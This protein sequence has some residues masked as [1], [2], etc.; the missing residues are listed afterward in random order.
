MAEA[1]TAYLVEAG[2]SQAAA[3]LTVQMAATFAIS[4]VATRVFAPDVPQTKD[5][6]SRQQVPPDTTTG[7]PVVYGDA[8]LGGKFVDA[9][10][11]ANQ[12]I[13]YYVMA[14]SC[15]SNNG[16]VTIDTTKMYYGDRLITFDPSN[17]T[18][19]ISLTDTA[20]NV[21][22]TIAGNNL[23]ISLYRSYANGTIVGLNT[24]V[25]PWENHPDVMHNGIPTNVNY[26]ATVETLDD[27]P[28]SASVNDGY[29]VQQAVVSGSPVNNVLYVWDGTLWN[30]T[31]YD[32]YRV[33]P[34][35]AWP[36][37]G[38]RMNG[39]V[40]AIIRMNYNQGANTTQLQP[41]T[42]KVSQYLN[43]TGCAKPGDVWYDY[44]TNSVY[45]GA[46][47]TTFVDSASAT[48]LNNYSDEL[49]TYTPSGG[50]ATQTTPR[51]RFNGV[52]DTG[53]TVLSN[54]DKIVTCCDSWMKYAV[55]EGSWA[56]VIN[57]AEI[58]SFSF[59]DSNIVGEI[60]VSAIDIS[61]AYNQIEAKF[62][63]STNRDQW[64]YVNQQVPSYLL[65]PNEPV[66]KY[67][68]TYDLI[69]DSVR[70]QYLANRILEQNREDLNVSFNSAYVGIQVNAGD[71]VSVTN[72]AYGWTNKLFRVMQ[73]KEVSLADGNLGASFQLIEYNSQ[74]YDNADITQY[75][76]APNGGLASSGFFSALI[77]PT[78]TDQ[79]QSAAVPS[80]SVDCVLP[81]TGR[82]TNITL[83]YSTVSTPSS[84]DWLVISIQNSVNSQPFTNG[85]TIKF[86][87]I[88]LPTNV[89]YFAFRVG[90]E[91]SQS[92]LSPTSTSFNWLP[93]P[94]S[95]SVAG[96]FVATWSPA[97]IQV[98]YNGTTA[99]FT[100]IVPQL[101]G[102]TSGGS[103]DF[104]LASSDTDPLFVDNSWRIGA[105]PLTGFSDIVKTNITI[106]NPTDGGNY[107]LFPTPTAM[108]AN[109]ATLEVPVRY[110]DDLGNIVQGATA[111]L[112]FA[113]AVQGD[114]GA[115]GS[116][117]ATAVLYQWSTSTPSNPNGTSTFTWATSS[118]GSYTGGNGWTTS[119]GANPGIPLIK[120]FTATKGISAPGNDVTTA[121]SW[122]SGFSVQEFTQ[123]GDNGT[124]GANGI[125]SANPT[126]YQWA[127]TIPS[128]PSGTSTYTWSSNTFTPT[129]AGW[130]LTGGT[131]PSEGYTL[132]AARVNLVESAT[133]TTSTINWT[134]S[135]IGAV[136]YAGTTGSTGT[137]GASARICY[138][139][140]TLSSLSSSPST[141]TTSGS[142]SYPPNDSWGSGTVWQATPPSIVAG[143][144]V[145]QSDGIYSPT[146]GNTI[147][148]VP[149]LSALKVGSLSAITANMGTLT[150]GK[151]QNAASTVVMNLDATGTS[152]FLNVNN[153]LI[154]KADGSASF[155]GFQ[156]GTISTT[157]SV[158][159]VE[160]GEDSD[161]SVLK[162]R[163][164]SSTLLPPMYLI[165]NATSGA[166]SALWINQTRPPPYPSTFPVS[167][168]GDCIFIT[169]N[170]NYG[171]N[172]S[173]P[174]TDSDT[175]LALVT[176]SRREGQM[177]V[178][179]YGSGHSQHAFRGRHYTA[180]PNSG[181]TL[182]SSG[183]VATE[184]GNAFYAEVGG[185]GPFTGV[186]DALLPNG[187][188][189]EIGDIM[190][191][192]QLIAKNG[193]S[194]T[195]W[196][197]SLSS[198]PNSVGVGIL[199][200]SIP[201]ST[202]VPA[203]LIDK[204]KTIST[205][206][207]YDPT[208]GQLVGETFINPPK[209]EYE[210]IKND[211]QLLSINAVGEGQ[212][213]VCGENGNI[214]KGDYIVISSTPG[215]GMKQSDNIYMNYTIARARESATFSSPNEV[216]M[217]ACIYLCG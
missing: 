147:W 188:T 132:W 125:Q 51:Y 208:T 71:V 153:K 46:V 197:V 127:I 137:T 91:T 105:T 85:S 27:L 66:N 26:I 136:G 44:I 102:T 82:I 180:N 106:G 145:Y 63:D 41:I 29:M 120:L 189:A 10:L 19:V 69:N 60:T 113:Y 196:S 50:G 210:L 167:Y 3:A 121:V 164:N 56:I 138:T 107:A 212:I 14:I 161:G 134:L 135:A 96:T 177:W 83:Y 59:D 84:T 55:T 12:H 61:S 47:D 115:T 53:Q 168:N 88:S 2:F 49:I 181:G 86:T 92:G 28:I 202:K 155:T 193:V 131:S 93:T 6:G 117:H 24:T 25:M 198:T 158:S 103:V 30:P 186:H 143:E 190:I 42:F 150:A 213:N 191:D 187:V 200:E 173:D 112:Q 35:Q 39:L 97:T 79:Q 38:R 195:L 5:N 18:G 62:P 175:R 123:N 109:N 94:T 205:G 140:T 15:A 80:F 126:V 104:V 73:V 54:I 65:Y 119:V 171:L 142:S 87:H 215:K 169:P 70:A 130:S 13:M 58:S 170:G 33:L 16:Q 176:G 156:A 75:I 89:Y 21:D 199:S 172:V 68:I 166:P 163:R 77:A 141:I 129:P 124:D 194:D 211:Y 52:L 67:T 149:Y 111:I 148:N 162:V 48:A 151:I 101:Y 100:G 37:T 74:V 185:Y 203:A 43:N 45:G 110:K 216:K 22:T 157:G 81:A 152:A 36:S 9:C 184:G 214:Q 179:G 178:V 34:S 128:A 165:D 57:K 72:S 139:K 122:S 118:N 174:T 192:D 64:N 7:I 95:T 183:I 31:D 209:P 20:G 116:Q 207:T 159:T 160:L 4:T 32:Q 217:I 40:F 1:A 98:P 99:T 182:N 114:T 108:A 23:N 78:V 204:E 11:S 76:P 144:S 206:K 146:T 8:Y 201:L 133:V 154:M 90:N 17:P